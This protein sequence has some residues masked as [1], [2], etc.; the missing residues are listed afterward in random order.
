MFKKQRVVVSKSVLRSGIMATRA[1]MQTRLADAGA[2]VVL[3]RQ[4]GRVRQ[5]LQHVQQ[6]QRIPQPMQCF[7]LPRQPRLQPLQH[8]SSGNT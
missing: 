8:L 3:G 4:A 2:A 5:G 7:L 6:R 1:R